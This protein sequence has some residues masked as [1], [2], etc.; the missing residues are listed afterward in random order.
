MYFEAL[1]IH[2]M[3][4][5]LTFT[6]TS[7]PRSKHEDILA[8]EEFRVLKIVTAVAAV[9]ELVVKVIGL[10]SAFSKPFS[11]AVLSHTSL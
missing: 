6:P 4:I 11:N 1:V 7:F 2:P 3:K 9:D 10:K 8:A 5:R